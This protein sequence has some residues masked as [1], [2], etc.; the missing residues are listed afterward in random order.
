MRA[1]SFA[2]F[3]ALVAMF[4]TAPACE[5]Y[6]PPPR[7][8]VV[9]LASGVLDDPRAPLVIHFGMPVDPETLS[10]KVALHETDIEGNLFDED[11]D[12]DTD[13]RVLL[14]HDRLD[15]DLGAHAALDPDGSTLRLTPE[16]ALPVGPKLVLIV[17]PGLR[18]TSGKEAR[19][20]QKI[21][22]SYVVKCASGPSSFASGTYF[23]LLEVEE[24]LGVQIQLLSHIE[25]DPK[26]GV[27]VGQFTNADRDPSL[28][29]PSPCPATDACRLLP[30]PECVP[31]SERAGAVD[32]YPDFSV[33]ATPPTGYSFFVRGC[34]V[35][36]GDASGVLTAPATMIVESPPVTVEGLTLTASF[37]PGADGIVR[38]TGS[39]TGDL[40]RL[41]SSSL[42]AGRGTMTA[43]RI[44]DDRVPA[45]VPRPAPLED[46]PDEDEDASL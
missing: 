20:R 12:P 35:D 36:D 40:I 39:L 7:A 28:V 4:A 1:L 33:N 19:F 6:E 16:A 14:R 18:A 9:G 22:F 43:L 3:C 38:A 24:P 10:V 37:A 42:G 25:V 30:A 26:T 11:D 44:P 5:R 23:M 15:G 13:L 8:A 17:E 21:P 29:C 34:A 32:E 41:G 2:L 45:D 27:L 31:P 46:E